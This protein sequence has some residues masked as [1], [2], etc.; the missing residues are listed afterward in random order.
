MSD[1]GPPLAN[2]QVE[3]RRP[4]PLPEHD[5]G[6]GVIGRGLKAGMGRVGFQGAFQAGGGPDGQAGRLLEDDPVGGGRQFS[7]VGLVQPVQSRRLPHQKGIRRL[8]GA[9]PFLLEAYGQTFLWR[10]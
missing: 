4:V 9:P 10:D 6:Q 3:I 1:P 2:R 8:E 5:F 7:R